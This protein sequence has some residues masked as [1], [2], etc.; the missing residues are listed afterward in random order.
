MT[1]PAPP[2]VWTVAGSDSGGGAG[3]QAD[4]RAFAAFEVHGCSAVAALTAQNSVEVLAAEPVSEA[5]LEAQL[6]ALAS[7]MPPAA[8]KTGMLGSAGN[9]RVLVRWI[10]RLRERQPSLPVIVDPVLGSTTGA[11]FA[12]DEL[13]QA[14]RRELL[15]RATLLTPN[16]REAAALLGVPPLADAAQVEQAAGALRE[17]GC[18]AVVITGGDDEG[19]ESRDYA[20][21]CEASGW[22][23]LPRVATSHHHGTGCVFASSAAAAMALG[24]VTIEAIVRAKMA[25]TQALRDARPAGAGA[26]PVRP[27]PGFA[28]R[29]ENLPAFTLPAP[30]AQRG[31]APGFAPLQDAH[32]GLYAIVDSAAWVQRV[33]DAGVRTVQLRIKDPQHP[34]LRDE[35]RAS[36]AAARAAGAQLFINDHWQAALEEGAYGVHLGQ[37]DLATADLDAIARAGLRLGVSTHAFWEVSRAWAL[38]PSYIACGPIHPTAA[39]AM[40][41]IPQGNG[42][43]A[44]WCSLLPLPVVAIAG[45]DTERAAQ[46]MQCGASSVAVISG[47]TAAASPE[48]AIAELQQALRAAGTLAAPELPRPTLALPLRA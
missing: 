5:M 41:W 42:N 23:S 48:R 12:N 44:Y 29:I 17:G 30:A 2:I 38:R 33:V 25:T 22:L 7:D 6:A 1:H 20:L 9:L 8:I 31:A 34:R 45:M 40:P 24:F 37:E 10:D 39:K 28:T 47:I 43:L 18:K 26:G 4:L 19:S 32:L 16:R 35:V 36:V 21:T 3:L 14:Y 46:A 27:L 15:P 13:L 11:S